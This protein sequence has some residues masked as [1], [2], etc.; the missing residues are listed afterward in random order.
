MTTSMRLLSVQPLPSLD[1]AFTS[2]W[3]PLMW[4][5]L[6]AGAASAHGNLYLHVTVVGCGCCLHDLPSARPGP[7]PAWS[8]RLLSGWSS[9]L[10]FLAV[11][12]TRYLKQICPNLVNQMT[13]GGESPLNSDSVGSESTKSKCFK[14][15]QTTTVAVREASPEVDLAETEDSYGEN[16][17]EF[18]AS[19]LGA[20]LALVVRDRLEMESELGQMD[21]SPV[22]YP[23]GRLLEWWS[24]G[25]EEAPQLGSGAGSY[26]EVGSG[27]FPT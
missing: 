22:S 5:L 7:S 23:G 8:L 2:A 4:P 24:S 9:L 12:R 19:R 6:H 20:L 26:K 25:R 3:P 11:V 13:D 18:D 21:G 10:H 15:T 14:K 1:V 27:K 16:V 17:L